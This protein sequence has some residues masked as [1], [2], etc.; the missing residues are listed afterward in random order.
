MSEYTKKLHIRKNG[1]VENITLYT[2]TS[3]ISDGNMLTLKDGDTNVY[4][5]LGEITD[6][7]ASSLRVKRGGVTYS[8]LKNTIATFTD[9]TFTVKNDGNTTI[10]T[11]A[12]G[13]VGI[14]NNKT[15]YVTTSQTPD[16]PKIKGISIIDLD[17]GYIYIFVDTIYKDFSGSIS[18]V[19]T[20]FSVTKDFDFND[21]FTYLA[22]GTVLKNYIKVH[23]GEKFTDNLNLNQGE[24]ITLTIKVIS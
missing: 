11:I 16:T 1:D 4:A 15:V 9:V 14:S 8:V 24:P 2:D 3:D 21:K 12:G 23:A 22:T 18:I 19:G 13:D 6:S 7:R 10:S 20:N 17:L 5:A